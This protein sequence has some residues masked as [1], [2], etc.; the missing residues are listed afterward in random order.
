MT[1]PCGC[2][3]GTR[4]HTPRSIENR[5]GLSALAYRVGTHGTFLESMLARLS[6]HRLPDG[7]R[8]LGALTVR[9]ADDPSI[10]VLDAWATVADILTFYQE[11]IANEGFLRTATERRSLVE[12]GRLLGYEL[13][14]ALSATA[15]L[16][17]T[18]ADDPTAADGVSIP[19][20]TRAQSIPEAGG[21]PQPFETSEPLDAR[22]AWNKLPVRVRQAPAI[23][24]VQAKRMRTI[25][26][27]G[28][29]LSLSPGDRLLFDFG[30]QEDQQ[31]V[32]EVASAK[33]D[34]NED[35]TRV[36]L[37]TPATFTQRL[38]DLARNL[39]RFRQL[40][41]F[42]VAATPEARA[43]A[44]HLRSI[45]S[46][47]RPRM[48]AKRLQAVL[49][50][51]VRSLRGDS[52]AW[53]SDVPEEAAWRGQAI[54]LVEP[55][56][57]ESDVK[58]GEVADDARLP[59]L[60]QGP[61]NL[62]QA[63]ARLA[64]ALERGPSSQP[65][66]AS[67]LARDAKS[68]FAAD[69]DI[70]P[71][72]LGALR[73]ELG[74]NVY[75]ALGGVRFGLPTRLR[76]LYVMRERAAPFGANAPLA[77]PDQ[78]G[79][80]PQ[81]WRLDGGVRPRPATAPAMDTSA[82]ARG[83]VGMSASNVPP[84]GSFNPHT[85]DALA[86]DREYRT[87]L[88]DTWVLLDWSDGATPAEFR[89][90]KVAK[91]ESLGAAAYNLSG[92][93]TR[94]HFDRDWAAGNQS[95]L[96]DAALS[97]I[98]GMTI[99]FAPEELEIAF[100]RITADV[101]GQEIAL[102]GVHAGLLPGRWLIVEGERT[103]VPQVEGL[104]GCELAMIASTRQVV[105][106]T[107]GDDQVHTIVRLAAPLRYRFKRQ[108]AEIWGNVAKATQGE[109]HTEVLGS[110]DA[111]TPRQR[112]SLAQRPL[113]YLPAATALGVRSTLEVRVDDLLWNEADELSSLSPGERGYI[114]HTD[115]EDATSVQFGDGTHGARL[116]TGPE[117]VRAVYRSGAG[118]SGN[119]PAGRISQLMT[120]PTGLRDVVN[121]LRSTGGADRESVAA[122]RKGIPLSV[123]ALDRIV[124]LRDYEDFARAR[125]G[126]GKASATR[127][128]VGGR[129]VV[130]LSVGGTDPA[131]LDADSDLVLAL[132]DALGRA[133][134]PHQPVRLEVC[135]IALIVVV[136]DV[137]ISPDRT[138][139]TV[140]AA[141]RRKLVETFAFE[142]RELGQHVYASE[143]MAAAQGV[144]GVDFFDLDGLALAPA[145]IDPVKLPQ[146]A[147]Q[148]ADPP[149]S[150]LDV[151][152]A[153]LDRDR[154]PHPAQLAVLSSAVPDTL[155]LRRLL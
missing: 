1:A 128:R 110:G 63:L 140:E 16:A 123:M 15:F 134:D 75:K 117:N 105:D 10:A 46:R 149:P 65:R 40:K 31:V 121:P 126:I 61:D 36:A 106:P 82:A 111:A 112:F 48:S 42:D 59:R 77:P 97:R 27:K 5:P 96:D 34:Y 101:T 24:S 90:G 150:R 78:E 104:T 91:V 139:P 22:P 45:Q 132:R 88:Q 133:G 131:P 38:E 58:S 70:A 68:L 72:L 89:V 130:H 148:L 153:R 47:L 124:S 64:P 141:V 54:A 55:A 28:T 25:E 115:D 3:E 151:Q 44:S 43:F 73:P 4:P 119:L 107:A 20:G 21:R 125:A 146:I 13:R 129:K 137:H 143:V 6:S 116:P 93:V 92:T 26:L 155:I 19:A 76:G 108:T 80:A 118:S 7:S 30:D 66:H 18:L 114:L 52:D 120:R 142:R 60:D 74:R 81:E 67:L 154:T 23:T 14:P 37:V 100:S 113:T 41:A 29:S 99:R 56:Q 49:G 83:D 32:R 62:T 135:E 69:S 84:T 147:E 33:P 102:R 145:G 95:D 103:D 109:S 136:A 53:S 51:G 86:L 50:E 57:F 17:F 2:C 85:T 152:M 12:L 122:A 79:G 94:L 144:E 87:A 71:A 127:L 35:L 98:R 9:T 138:W 8:P 39:A 11:R